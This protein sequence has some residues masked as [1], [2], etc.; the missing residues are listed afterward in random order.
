MRAAFDKVV[1]DEYA[2]KHK[3]VRGDWTPIQ[4]NGA[5][6]EIDHLLTIGQLKEKAWL[7]FAKLRYFESRKR[8]VSARVRL[9][10][11]VGSVLTLKTVV[12]LWM[13]PG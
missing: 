5:L 12:A 6:L 4:L 8:Y 9:N 2:L 7:L 10:V 1:V 13:A 11:Q 3:D